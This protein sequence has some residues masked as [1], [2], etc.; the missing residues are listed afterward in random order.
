MENYEFWIVFYECEICIC[1]TKYAYLKIYKG[2][3]VKCFECVE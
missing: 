2:G 1:R 3:M